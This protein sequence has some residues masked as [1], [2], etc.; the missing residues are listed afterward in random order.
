MLVIGLT[1]GI[2]T[3]KSEV[4][5]ILS[6]LGA[7]IIDADSVGHDAYKPD[8]QAWW[9][10]VEAFGNGILKPTGEV[11]R[12]RL[13]T[14]VFNDPDARGKLNA[15]MHPKMA[16]TIR[17]RINQLRGEGTRVVVVEAALLIDAGWHP[18]VDEVWVTCSSEDEVA[19]R[20]RRRNHLSQEE[21]RGRIGS[22]LP[23]EERSKYAHARLQNSGSMDE[24]RQAVKM[25]WRGRVE[26]KVS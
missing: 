14:I 20:L 13:G 22:Q 3:G 10:V 17:E 1:G 15:I 16:G 24:L 26:G 11:D 2:A 9:E 23:Y 18:L 12:K 8:S 25:L 21:I 7:T 19:E 6:E 5:R 4:S